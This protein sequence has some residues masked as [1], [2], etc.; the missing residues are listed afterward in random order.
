MSLILSFDVTRLAR[1]CSDWYPLLDL[2][3]SHPP[4]EGGFPLRGG[5]KQCLIADRDGVYDPGSPNGR[6]LLGLKGQLSELELHTPPKGACRIRARMTAGLLNKAERG[7]LAL[8]LP[9][10]LVRS[11]A[12]KVTQDA[13]REVQ[14]RLHLVF[15]TFLQVRS[16]CKVLQFFQQH[17]LLLPRRDRFGDLNWKPPS[18]GGWPPSC[19]FSRIRLTQARLCMVARRSSRLGHCPPTSA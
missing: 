9:V 15:I 8:A 13:N 1:N 6:L 11:A 14:D 10:G 19:R 17:E 5:Y 2:C 3:G 16:A 18:V 4:T 12:G 7:E